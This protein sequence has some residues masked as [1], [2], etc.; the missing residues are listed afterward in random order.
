MMKIKICGLR[1]AATARAALDLG[2]DYLGFVLAPSRRRVSP[3]ELREIVAALP[4]DAPTVGVFVNESA[5][6]IN[7]VVAECGLK[8][9]QLSGDEPP[10]VVAAVHRPVFKAVRIGGPNPPA[11]VPSGEEEGILAF[12]L[13]SYQP[14][15]YGGTGQIGDWELA[16]AIAARYPTFLAGGLK[17]EN[18]EAAIAQVRPLG[19]DVSS[20]V[21]AAGRPGHKDVARIAA[22]IEAV[23]RVDR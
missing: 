21:E 8:Y 3:A 9:A 19:V 22:F 11:P 18:V 4:P 10:E 12:V 16:A 6:T 7:L 15:T 5:A 2:A 14:G 13:D 1:D 17:P 23:R 20:G